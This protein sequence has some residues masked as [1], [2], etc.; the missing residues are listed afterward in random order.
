MNAQ[1]VSVYINISRV[2][3]AKSASRARKKHVYL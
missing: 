2:Q 3:Q 1:N